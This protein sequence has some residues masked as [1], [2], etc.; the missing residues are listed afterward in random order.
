MYLGS[1]GFLDPRQFGFKSGCSMGIALTAMLVG[2]LVTRDENQM[3]VNFFLNLTLHPSKTHA[4]LN[5]NSFV[6]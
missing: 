3:S 6:F 5:S 1:L 2:L 4:Y